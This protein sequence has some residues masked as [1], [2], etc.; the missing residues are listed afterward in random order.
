VALSKELE[1]MVASLESK[2]AAFLR[3]LM[4]GKS[5]TAAYQEAYSCT[6]ES[7]RKNAHRV[8]AND[9]FRRV[10]ERATAEAFGGLVD[11]LKEL[12]PV[13]LRRIRGILH[14]SENEAVVV[15]LIDSVLDRLGVVRTERHEVTA[16]HQYSEPA[17]KILAQI[18]KDIEEDE[19]AGGERH[20]GTAG[21][22]LASLGI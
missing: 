11:G 1:A 17:R 3:G 21:R 4:E 6:R 8:T 2:Q 19:D 16:P 14:E 10:Y 20:G 5:K 18:R 9:G 7:A 13:I 22:G 15:R 12:S